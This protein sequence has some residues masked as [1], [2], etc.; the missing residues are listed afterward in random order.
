MG[1]D[2]G[3]IVKRSRATLGLDTGQEGREV[4][5]NFVVGDRKSVV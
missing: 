1:G 3:M 4:S 2:G 5:S